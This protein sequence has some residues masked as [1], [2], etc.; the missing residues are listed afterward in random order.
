MSYQCLSQ[1]LTVVT[2]LL[3]KEHVILHVDPE[4]NPSYGSLTPPKVGDVPRRVGLGRGR[5][6]G[7]REDCEDGVRQDRGSHS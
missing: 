7:H 4:G 2:L 6:T 1:T 5:T 3:L